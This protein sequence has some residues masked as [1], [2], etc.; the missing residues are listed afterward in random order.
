VSAVLCATYCCSKIVSC[1]RTCCCFFI[2]AAVRAR[3][4]Y[5]YVSNDIPALEAVVAA[6]RS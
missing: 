6:A 1:M 2:L 5:T 4:A 3:V